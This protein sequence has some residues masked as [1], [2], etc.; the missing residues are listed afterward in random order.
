[1]ENEELQAKLQEK[2][3]NEDKSSSSKSSSFDSEEF[4]QKVFTGMT[5]VVASTVEKTVKAVHE[6]RKPDDESEQRRILSKI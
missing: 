3:K 1:M 6:S 4:L 2:D 5:A